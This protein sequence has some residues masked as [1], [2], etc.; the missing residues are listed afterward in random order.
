MKTLSALCAAALVVSAHVSRGQSIPGP[1]PTPTPSADHRPFTF[2]FNNRYLFDSN[3]NHSLDEPRETRGAVF[4]LETTW[5][6]PVAHPSFEISYEIARHF[7]TA[8][9]WDRLS[10]D[11]RAAWDQRLSK[12]WYA[13]TV[14]EVSLKGSTE[15][16]DISDQYIFSPRIEYRFNRENRLR[17]YG[18]YR[19]RKFEEDPE[20]NAHNRYVG[21]E[22]L[23]RGSVRRLDLGFRYEINRADS[24]RHHYTRW[25]YYA[26]YTM[27]VSRR[28][29]LTLSADYRPR[30]YDVRRVDVGDHEELRFDRNW[31]LFAAAAH[32]LRPDLDVILEY[33][34]ETRSS[35]DSDKAFD[36]HSAA[37]AIAY[38]F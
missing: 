25:T 29:R 36:E 8:K 5:K 11:V 34:Y 27:P 3:I 4:G 32:E 28:D 22:Y 10:H 17:G 16:R 37:A 2:T 31:I 18:A 35:N 14:G 7:H 21:A 6:T 19:I 9:E 13:E 38:R 26:E 12:H 24:N 15:D 30:R 33:R 23:Y 1:A 20:R